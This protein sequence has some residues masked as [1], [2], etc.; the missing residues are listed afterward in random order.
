MAVYAGLSIAVLAG[1]AL[2]SLDE[3]A[4]RWQPTRRWPQWEPLMS[5]WVLLGQRL[6][7]LVL[8]G[9]WLAVRF[10]Q[11]RDPRP[12][13]VATVAV[14][15]LNATVGAAKM[16]F[17]R[18][19]PLQ[20]GDDALR[21][22]A[23]EVFADGMVFPSGHA[24]NAVAMWGLAAYLVTRHRRLAAVVVVL[25]AVSVGST[26]VYLGTH[27]VSDVLAGWV[28]GALVV[29]ALP[30]VGSLADRA[31]RS[32]R[33]GA[34]ERATQPAAGLTA[35]VHAPAPPPGGIGPVAG[36]ASPGRGCGHG[37]LS[38]RRTPR[39]PHARS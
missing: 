17:G 23:A 25:L 1:S 15:L 24:A 34:R 11:D 30:T 33:A 26:T 35:P 27:W 8:I 19:G 16:A 20:L 14:L 4:L 7:C 38:D 13:L 29:L 39:Q 31:Y 32:R 5:H 37:A 12:L 21:P 10:L 2:V 22:G 18:L 3:E 6:V 36:G 9:G 28:A